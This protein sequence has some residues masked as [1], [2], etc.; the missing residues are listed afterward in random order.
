MFLN[1]QSNKREA[2]AK[3]RKT[4]YFLDSFSV[5]VRGVEK[6]A[7]SAF[8][9]TDSHSPPHNHALTARRLAPV[10]ALAFAR[11]LTIM[12]AIPTATPPTIKLNY[13]ACTRD[14]VALTRTRRA[15]TA[16]TA[17]GTAV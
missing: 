13:V 1:Q 6:K 8:L 17:G 9:L 4:G 11:A 12:I 2:R 3:S 5:M 14:T 15:R 10:L 16:D 7:T